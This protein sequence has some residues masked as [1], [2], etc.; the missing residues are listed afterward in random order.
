MESLKAS[1]TVFFRTLRVYL[2]R[3]RVAAWA[4]GVQNTLRKLLIALLEPIDRLIDGNDQTITRSA[5][6]CLKRSRGFLLV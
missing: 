1:H 3:N 5:L 6:L 4:I 2:L